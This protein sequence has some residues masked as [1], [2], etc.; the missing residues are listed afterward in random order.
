MGADKEC[1]KKTLKLSVFFSILG[2]ARANA[3]HKTLMKFTPE[4]DNE[5][6][7]GTCES[8]LLKLG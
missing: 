1:A 4:L 7:H 5:E 2:S 3:A 8:S 6:L